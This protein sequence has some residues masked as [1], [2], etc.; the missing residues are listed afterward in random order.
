M[1][2][3]AAVSAISEWLENNKD[4]FV[5]GISHQGVDRQIAEIS[6]TILNPPSQ[7]YV[8][9]VHVRRATETLSD[10]RNS[11][12]QRPVVRYDVEVHISD[13]AVPQ[14]SDT[15]PYDTVHADFRTVVSRIVYGLR[16]ARWFPDSTSS[17]RY[18]LDLPAATISV[19]DR[20]AWYGQNSEYPIL[21]AVIS[22]SLLNECGDGGSL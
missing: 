2:I 5:S 6:P 17:P 8:I 15:V 3:D 20:T 14:S 16:G 19:E 12:G 11:P 4:G 13:L 18:R 10:I 9:A 21:Y 1:N 22:F 7:Y